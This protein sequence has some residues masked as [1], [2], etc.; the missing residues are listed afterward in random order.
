MICL[1]DYRPNSGR[2]A[3]ASYRRM[4]CSHAVRRSCMYD[5]PCLITDSVCSTL[6]PTQLNCAV[7]ISVVPRRVII[8]V[9]QNKCYT[10]SKL[11][12]LYNPDSFHSHLTPDEQRDPVQYRTVRR[13]DARRPLMMT[14]LPGMVRPMCTGHHFCRCCDAIYGDGQSAHFSGTPT[15]ADSPSCFS[16]GLPYKTHW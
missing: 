16:T 9:D 5:L 15:M 1:Q 13:L 4:E 10:I 7:T 2:S 3:A 14:W 12:G 6:L 11:Q 8:D